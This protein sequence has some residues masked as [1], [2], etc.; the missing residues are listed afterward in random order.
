MTRRRKPAVPAVGSA[1]APLPPDAPSAPALASQLAGMALGGGTQPQPTSPA[2]SVVAI[3]AGATGGVS[4]GAGPSSTAPSLSAA[5]LSAGGSSGSPADS[6]PEPSS[7][8]ERACA[9]CTVV[10]AGKVFR[11]SRCLLVYYCGKDCQASALAH[12]KPISCSAPGD[13]SEICFLLPTPRSFFR[14]RTGALR[15]RPCAASPRR[16]G[17]VLSCC[18]SLPG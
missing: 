9:C 3:S 2:E 17:R 8:E 1:A 14:S 16:E 11:C 10:I 12:R 13:P 18:L 6:T 4:T 7:A 5:S 15:T